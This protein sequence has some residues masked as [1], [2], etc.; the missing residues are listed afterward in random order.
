MA[1]PLIYVASIDQIHLI[2]L[3]P[4]LGPAMHS[5]QIQVNIVED[6]K[7]FQEMNAS[8]SDLGLPPRLTTP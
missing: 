2:G 5:S 6:D 1:E 3:I 7:T 8:M 4:T